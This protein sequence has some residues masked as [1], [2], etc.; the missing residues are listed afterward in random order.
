MKPHVTDQEPDADALQCLNWCHPHCQH[1][2]TV[3]DVSINILPSGLSVARDGTPNTAVSDAE[4]PHI[5]NATKR[6]PPMNKQRKKLMEQRIKDHPD[7]AEFIRKLFG[8]VER[9]SRKFKEPD[10]SGEKPVL[11][12]ED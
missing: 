2:A 11:E 3:R 9:D 8:M 12:E 4:W 1:A 7:Q 5:E 10:D 6:R